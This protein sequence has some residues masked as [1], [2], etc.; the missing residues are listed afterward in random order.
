M[1]GSNTDSSMKYSTVH[2]YMCVKQY[3][4]IFT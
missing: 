1:D 2:M 3:K 4:N